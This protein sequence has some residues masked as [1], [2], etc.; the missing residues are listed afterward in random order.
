MTKP[1]N[2]LLQPITYYLMEGE[3]KCPVCE[4]EG[5]WLEFYMRELGGYYTPC[6]ACNKTGKVSVWWMIKNHFWNIVPI[7]FI[8]WCADVYGWLEERKSSV[9]STD[10]SEE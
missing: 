4:G 5:E 7:C 1:K 8:E 9:A 3:M 2:G 10:E 6:G